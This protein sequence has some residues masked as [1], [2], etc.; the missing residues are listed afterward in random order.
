[1]VRI[2]HWQTD[3]YEAVY[4][5]GKKVAHGH[6]VSIEEAVISILENLGVDFVFSGEYFDEE[7]MEKIGWEFPDDIW[8]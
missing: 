6:S 8:A 3:D 7:Q 4:V 5:N 2:T 1:M